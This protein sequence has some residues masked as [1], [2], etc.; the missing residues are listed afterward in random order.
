MCRPP[1]TRGYSSSFLLSPVPQPLAD[2]RPVKQ[3]NPLTPLPPSLSPHPTL[4]ITKGTSHQA[5]YIWETSVWG[6]GVVAGG[7][8]EGGASFRFSEINKRAVPRGDG[9]LPG[10]T[11]PPCL[12]K[13]VRASSPDSEI[14]DAD[15]PTDRHTL[16][17]HK[18]RFT[19]ENQEGPGPLEGEGLLSWALPQRN[20]ASVPQAPTAQGHL[21]EVYLLR[22][23]PPG[24]LYHPRS[25]LPL[26]SLLLCPGPKT[27]HPSAKCNLQYP[28]RAKGK[29]T[30]WPS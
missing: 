28:T 1:G 9:W 2:S 4:S 10:N 6:Q 19:E 22:S 30:P 25:Q 11:R 18:G 5:Y 27:L 23:L 7:R 8:G 12:H 14:T 26:L 17:T 15:R 20:P 24:E 16:T 29:G 13:P 3:M 21:P